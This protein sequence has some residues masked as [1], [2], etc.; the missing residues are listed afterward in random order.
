[1]R[2]DKILRY[3]IR[4]IDKRII[5]RNM[6]EF[7]K[8][9]KTL[10]SFYRILFS[11]NSKLLDYIHFL[12]FERDCKFKNETNK[13]KCTIIIIKNLKDKIKCSRLFYNR[14]FIGLMKK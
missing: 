14:K 3:E 13:I 6:D 11:V 12:F 8:I 2:N 9:I 1:M 7:I 5:C 10:K 4:I